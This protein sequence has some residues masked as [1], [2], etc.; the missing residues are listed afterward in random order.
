MKPLEFSTLNLTIS[1]VVVYKLAAMPTWGPYDH[2]SQT[3]N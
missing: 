2:T 1:S 3:L